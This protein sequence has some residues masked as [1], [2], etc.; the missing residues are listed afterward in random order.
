VT[1]EAAKPEKSVHE[2]T[3][4]D[5]LNS[6]TYVTASALKKRFNGV[7]VDEVYKGRAAPLEKTV[8]LQKTGGLWPRLIDFPAHLIPGVCCGRIR[9][10]QMASLPGRNHPS[11]RTLVS[12]LCSQ[13]S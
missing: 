2:M 9:S 5:I 11:L 13:L 7:Y 6:D 4:E 10:I 1:D 8:L 3:V 12:A